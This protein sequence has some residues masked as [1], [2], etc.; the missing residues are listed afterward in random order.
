MIGP[1]FS[2]RARTDTQ[3]EHYRKG[4]AELRRLADRIEADAD[5]QDA[6]AAARRSGAV[7]GA[8]RAAEALRNADRGR[9]RITYSV[10][11]ASSLSREDLDAVTQAMRGEFPDADE[12]LQEAQ[13]RAL[14]LSPQVQALLSY[15]VERAQ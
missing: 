15:G 3:P 2:K 6:R 9:W 14:S 13:R 12:A 4:A 1:Q 10:G 11:R 8:Y 7:E 5:A